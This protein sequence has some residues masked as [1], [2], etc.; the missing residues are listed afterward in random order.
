MKTNLKKLADEIARVEGGKLNLGTPQISEVLG[1][2]GTR[3]RDMTTSEVLSE[4]SCIAD[5][6]GKRGMRYTKPQTK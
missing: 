4:I 2:L 5:R 1:C 3:W 6:A